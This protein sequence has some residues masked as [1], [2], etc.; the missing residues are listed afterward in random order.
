MPE[1]LVNDQHKSMVNTI[2]T[3]THVSAAQ[4]E[5]WI[6][7]YLT[8]ELEI[9]W[10]DID[11]TANFDSFGLSSMEIIGLTGDLELHLNFEFDPTW[12]YEYTT[13]RA[14]SEHISQVIEQERILEL[15]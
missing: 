11:A 13:I 8:E 14:L 5:A 3:P 6:L 1:K 9:K 10:D 7:N 12:V 4:I 2:K 15:S